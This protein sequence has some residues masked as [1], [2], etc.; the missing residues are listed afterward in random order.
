MNEGTRRRVVMIAL[1]AAQI[2]LMD[3]WSSDGTLPH[4]QELR[5]S[6][7]WGTIH[8]TVEWLTGTPWPS[9]YSGRWPS[10]HGYLFFLQWRPE[11]M[12]HERANREWIDLDAFYRFGE[13]GPRTVAVDMPLGFE[14]RPFNGVEIM[15]WASH[16]KLVPL[17][18]HPPEVRDWVLREFG[19]QP[20]AEEVYG[21]QHPESLLRLRDKLIRSA[22]LQADLCEVL[23]EREAWDLFMVCFG[24][25][26]RAGHKLWDHTSAIDPTKAE[27]RELDDGLRQVTIATDRAVGRLVEAAGPDATIIAYALHGM[28]P[29]QSRVQLLPEMLDRVLTDERR[30]GPPPT[31]DRSPLH[32]LR[33]MIPIE[34]RNEVKRR[35][36]L[37]L[38]DRLAKFWVRADRHDWS[39]TRAFCLFGDLEGMIQINLEGRESEGIVSPEEY[40][41]LVEE[42]R[43]GLTSFVDAD[44]GEPIIDEIGRGDR[45]WPDST[46]RINMPD[47]I[48]RW[49][50]SPVLHQRA[51]ASPRYGTIENPHAGVHADGRSGHHLPDGWLIGA[52]AGI[53][54]GSSIGRVHEFD[55]N[56]TVHALLGVDRP[57]E[58]RGDVIAGLGAGERSAGRAG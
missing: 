48:V 45:I 41:S 37:A 35:L 8:S 56:A 32:R 57:Q 29:N 16:D 36:P 52:G 46:Q 54:P 22:A 44:T 18:S 42:I 50:P 38:Q 53:A 23:I 26:H 11:L 15:S 17:V 55:L 4:L 12:R 6:G 27:R 20:V 25:V 31:T 58:T 30:D 47:L 1:D 2:D 51:I 7:A 21:P 13:D 33:R 34:W 5:E 43:E 40:D 39:E 19:A 14:P 10:E 49:V 3:R 9:F 24:G 28:G